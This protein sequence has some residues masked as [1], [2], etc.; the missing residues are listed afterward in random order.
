MANE[1]NNKTVET[2]LTE[3]P[4]YENEII[5]IIRG[6]YSPKTAQGMLED[7]H[8]SDVA[9]VM[10]NLN[11]QERKKLYRICS[12]EMLADALEHLEEDDA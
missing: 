3:R 9:Q 11:S 2:M 7:Y 1:I 10:E 12:A 6:S 5:R 4:D 8:G